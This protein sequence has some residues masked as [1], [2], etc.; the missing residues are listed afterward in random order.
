MMAMKLANVFTYWETKKTY[1]TLQSAD[2]EDSLDNVLDTH[3]RAW[4]VAI[5]TVTH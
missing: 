2:T 5:E 1:L 3:S 4:A